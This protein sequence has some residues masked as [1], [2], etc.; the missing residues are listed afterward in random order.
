M[1]LL[2]DYPRGFPTKTKKHEI[3]I[4]QKGKGQSLRIKEKRDIEKN[5]DNKKIYRKNVG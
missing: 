1:L 4:E 2:E 5:I 3:E